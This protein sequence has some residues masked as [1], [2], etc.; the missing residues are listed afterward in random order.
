MEATMNR[1]VDVV[2]AEL[3][4]LIEAH[5]FTNDDVVAIAGPHLRRWIELLTGDFDDPGGTRVVII[6]GSDSPQ[7]R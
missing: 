3:M 4:A 7:T 1:G 2:R 6:S 5:G